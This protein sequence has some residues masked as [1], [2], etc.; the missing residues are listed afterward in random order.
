[1]RWLLDNTAALSTGCQCIVAGTWTPAAHKAFNDM[2]SLLDNTAA[3]STGYISAQSQ[4][5]RGLLRTKLLNSV[6]R[7]LDNTAAL[8][9][10]EVSA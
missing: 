7:L 1:M 4:A 10:L 5:R 9:A 3:L 8:A 6:R 2:R